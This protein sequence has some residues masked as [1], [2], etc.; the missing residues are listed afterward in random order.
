MSFLSVVEADSAVSPD[1]HG[2]LG[3]VLTSFAVAEQALGQL[4]LAVGLSVEKGSLGNLE[5]LRGRIRTVNSTR[6]NA[7]D[8]RIERWSRNRPIRHLLAHATISVLHDPAG[9]EM[10]VTRHLPRDRDDVTPDRVWSPEERAE[11]L[12][13]ARADGRSICDRVKT[14]L[15][16]PVLLAKLRA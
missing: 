8:N 7:L 11:I 6:L 5:A 4:S 13:Q 10:I 15:A 14:M 1:P 12:R 3:Q 16:D 2:W 9:R